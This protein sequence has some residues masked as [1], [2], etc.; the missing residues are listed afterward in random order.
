MLHVPWDYFTLSTV[1]FKIKEN[2][3]VHKHFCGSKL[4]LTEIIFFT[5]N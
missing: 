2:Q 4:D 1:C 3:G 5:S